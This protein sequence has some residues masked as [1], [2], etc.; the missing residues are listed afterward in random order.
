MTR[1]RSC[2]C[3]CDNSDLING[4]CDECR[5]QEMDAARRVSYLKKIMDIEYE[6]F[7]QM[8]LDLHA[9]RTHFNGILN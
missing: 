5:S 3:Y 4:M 2:S 1:C 6:G 7:E 8:E 9:T